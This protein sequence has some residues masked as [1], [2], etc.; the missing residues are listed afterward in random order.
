MPSLTPLLEAAGAD[1]LHH[2]A[3]ALRALRPDGGAEAMAVGL[4]RMLRGKG[5]S[6]DDG[7]GI[8]ASGDGSGLGCD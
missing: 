1:V 3:A 6:V 2:Y 5:E 8:G 7:E 4:V